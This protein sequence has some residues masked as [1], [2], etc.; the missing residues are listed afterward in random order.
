VLRDAL[1][2][3]T[4]AVVTAAASTVLDPAM[5]ERLRSQTFVVWLT[6]EPTTLARRTTG[7]PD[8]PRLAPDQLTLAE[9]QR[10]E[11]DPLFADVA[12]LLVSTD[13]TIGSVVDDVVASL[14]PG[15]EASGP[16]RDV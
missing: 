12:D 13:G 14:P 3:P 9:R 8:R 4:P 11:R 6:A 5:R 1:D 16:A 7:T 2:A 15:T 10:V